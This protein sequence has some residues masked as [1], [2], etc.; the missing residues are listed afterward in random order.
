MNYLLSLRYYFAAQK[1]ANYAS[2][3][4]HKSSHALWEVGDGIIPNKTIKISAWNV[5]GFRSI[6]KKGNL[7]EFIENE[8]PDI[9]CLNETKLDL[10]VYEK[11]R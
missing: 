8:Q 6:A 4:L 3:P 2:V 7:I 11:F 5:N 9:I 10:K 1:K